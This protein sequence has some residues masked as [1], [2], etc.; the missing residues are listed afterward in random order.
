MSVVIGTRGSAL[1]L[2]QTKLV[3]SRLGDDAEIRVLHTAGDRSERPI[4]ALGDGAFVAA[5][6]E[7]LLRREIDAA[8]HSLKD[9]PTAERDGLVIAA[10][11]ERQ[12]PRDVLITRTRGG[13]PSLPEGA[14][15]GTSSPRRAAFLRA[16]RRDAV[17]REI[18][19]NVDTRLRKVREGEYE[20]A[21]LALA[22]LRRLGVAVDDGEVLDANAMP[23]APGQ[24]AL[25][26]QCRAEDR[27][28]RIRLERLDVPEIH[29]AVRAERALLSALGA[30]CALR[31][32]ALARADG[33]VIRLAA[34]FA[35]GEEIVRFEGAG[36][37]PD[38]VA[39]AAMRAFS[40]SF[41]DGLT[42]VLTR[43][44]E[45]DRELAEDLGALR[46]RILI[47]P[48]I[49]TEPLADGAGL[50]RAI[51]EA[52][53]DDVIVVTSRAGAAA[54]GPW[55]AELRAPVAA[56]GWAT[57]KELRAFG[58]S[59]LFVARSPSAIALGRELPIPRGTVVLARSD[60]A[61]GALPAVLRGRGARVRE[62]IAY[63]TVVAMSGEV[64][65][66][67]AAIW[68]GARPV[69]VFASPSAVDG[70]VERIDAGSLAYARP[71]AIGPT[72]ARRIAQLSGVVATTAH[73]PDVLS[74]VSAVV[75]ASHPREETVHVNAG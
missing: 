66:V 10:I 17:T 16:L 50:A 69:I 73:S 43:D 60:R 26:V 13:L 39:A 58:I 21:V 29:I 46:A 30:S 61:T 53:A 72:T 23:P 54:I 24:G 41:L 56:V 49:R 19:G 40:A 75:A 48:C 64:D 44:E 32:G 6:E 71:V 37:D 5:I 25:A 8:V 11:P 31:L 57:A 70:F 63:R 59:P 18:R 55:G 45:D 36:P 62:E 3:A 34:A 47:A 51:A 33:R 28:L 42:V 1:A 74:L 12:D 14:V 38:S 65:A 22:G 4:R 15:V 9:L 27:S 67:R 52:G 2:A 68:A 35:V 20:A 7:A